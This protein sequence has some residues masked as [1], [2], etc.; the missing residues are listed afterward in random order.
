MLQQ[1]IIIR[2]NTLALFIVS[3]IV[4]ELRL[5][6]SKQPL[7]TKQHRILGRQETI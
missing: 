2:R 5:Q 1:N 3:S 7:L 4:D 6:I